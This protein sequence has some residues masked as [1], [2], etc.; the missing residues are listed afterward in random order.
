MDRI[1]YV[2]FD[3]QSI[4]WS[5]EDGVSDFT[6]ADGGR[7]GNVVEHPSALTNAKTYMF[8]LE[9]QVGAIVVARLHEPVGQSYDEFLVWFVG[10]I[11]Y[12][13][14]IREDLGLDDNMKHIQ[15]SRVN[16]PIN[17]IVKLYTLSY[18]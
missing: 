15:I 1:A 2:N 9:V 14:D 17:A 10:N 16:V 8:V 13:L 18:S 6:V 12:N 5:I 7:Q 4:R 3:S 11:Q